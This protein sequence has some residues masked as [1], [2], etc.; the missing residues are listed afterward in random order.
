MHG[1]IWC[2]TSFTVRLGATFQSGNVTSAANQSDMDAVPVC[3]IE[4][5]LR[6]ARRYNNHVHLLTKF[7]GLWGKLGMNYAKNSCYLQISIC[8]IGE[9]PMES[10]ELSPEVLR[11][12]SK[13]IR[14]ITFNI[15]GISNS[16]W[17]DWKKVSPEKEKYITKLLQRLD[18]PDKELGMGYNSGLDE[19]SLREIFSKYSKLFESFSSLT[20]WEFDA[21]AFV[22]LAQSMVSTGRLQ[23]ICI[24][25][26]VPPV[27]PSSFWVDYFFSESCRELDAHFEDPSVVPE[28]INRWKQLDPRTL[29]PLKVCDGIRTSPDTL[30]DVGMKPI[31]LET[32]DPEVL[33]KIQ[34]RFINTIA[35][36]HCIDHPTHP[37]VKIYVIVF[38]GLSRKPMDEFA[39]LFD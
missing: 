21:P 12:K 25:D 4:A 34:R 11:E 5:V 29:T 16:H 10:R 27:L 37:H 14:S 1:S 35:S 18:A 22:N 13:N 17:D 2:N 31:P 15:S 26:P 6:R 39:L 19:S 23:S 8:A 24:W 38:I 36:L 33:G 28:L 30:V 20:L 7:S 3:F 32:A 9:R